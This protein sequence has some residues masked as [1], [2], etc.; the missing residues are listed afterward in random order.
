MNF[1][2]LFKRYHISE[3]FS[4]HVEGHGV[5]VGCTIL[6]LTLEAWCKSKVVASFKMSLTVCLNL[7][8][9]VSRSIFHSYSDVEEYG[10]RKDCWDV[11]WGKGMGRVVLP[12]LLTESKRRRIRWK[13]SYFKRRKT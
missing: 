9:Y 13:N 6:Y 3:I 10:T 5:F 2:V 12:P 7:T 1:F 8:A 11:A 4:T